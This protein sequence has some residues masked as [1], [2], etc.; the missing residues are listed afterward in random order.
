M[1][2][3]NFIH[4]VSSPSKGSVFFAENYDPMLISSFIVVA[5]FAS[6]VSL[7]VSRH[8]S[9]TTSAVTRW[10]WLAYV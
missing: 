4:L 3:R 1:V 8:V 5:I 6:Y 10:I 7:L 9:I 2:M